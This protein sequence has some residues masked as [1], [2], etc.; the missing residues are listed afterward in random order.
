MFPNIL[1]VAR[2]LIR[3]RV[4]RG[5]T[6]IDATMGNGH[7]TLF[8][9]QLVGETGRVIAYDIQPAALEKTAQRLQEAGV[10]QHVEL[11]LA[12]HEQ[13]N[14]VTEPVSAIM[15]NLG[16]LPGGNKEIT[17]QAAGTIRAIQAGLERLVP[18]GIITI[19][20]YW[21]HQAGKVEKDAVLAFC[22]Q[23]DQSEYLVL[24]YQ[25]LNQQNQAPFLIAIEKRTKCPPHKDN[26]E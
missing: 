10:D 4:N 26:I 8:L 9:A 7:D 24:R 14:Q 12:S 13:L 17:T 16:Y 18:G 6:V 15:F 20:V 2:K 25:Y 22:E 1:E 5:N 3:E 21:G 19:V 23:L 11:C